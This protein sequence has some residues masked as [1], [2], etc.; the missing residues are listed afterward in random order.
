[1]LFAGRIH[2]LRDQWQLDE[3]PIGD[4]A[5]GRHDLDRAD[6]NITRFTS[7]ADLAIG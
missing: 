1:M 4:R 2:Q 7:S 3:R 5:A 6:E